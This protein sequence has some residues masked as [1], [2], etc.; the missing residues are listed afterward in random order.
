MDE[1]LHWQ[2]TSSD[3]FSLL[4]QDSLLTDVGWRY[5]RPGLMILL[6][7]SCRGGISCY[8]SFNQVMLHVQPECRT[9]Y[10][11]KRRRY[12]SA[13]ILNMLR[14]RHIP[15]F[16]S[17]CS[18]YLLNTA[19]GIE[20]SMIR[21]SIIRTHWLASESSYQGSTQLRYDY[22]IPNPS[23]ACS[24]HVALRISDRVLSRFQSVRITH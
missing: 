2:Q 11:K 17:T 12:I 22:A 14:F 1:D 10:W 19:I 7:A 9:L 18:R 6:E 15:T 8:T 5:G 3:S 23:T 13:Q 24:V 4:P 21:L 16:S 20:Y